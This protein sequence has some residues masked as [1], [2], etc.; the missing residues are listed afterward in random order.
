MDGMTTTRFRRTA[1]I[2]D[3]DGTLADVRGIRHYVAAKPK[4]FDA[5]HAASAH[6]PAN[7]QAI[8]FVTQAHADGHVVIVVTARMQKWFDVT[9]AWLARYM[10]VPFDGPFHRQDGDV[11]PDIQVKRDIYRYLIRHYDIVGAVDDNPNVIAL[12]DSV[13]IPTT[14]IPGWDD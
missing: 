11:R 9:T 14:V 8:D 6:V 5:F 10:P 1:V 13:G 4:N 7:Q 12:W 3:M 2:A